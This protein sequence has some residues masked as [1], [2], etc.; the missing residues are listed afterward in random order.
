[1]SLG[2]CFKKISPHYC[3]RMHIAYKLA[4]FSVFGLKDKKLIKSKPTWKPETCKLYSR[5]F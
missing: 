5:D 3:W 1:M 4:L 2:A